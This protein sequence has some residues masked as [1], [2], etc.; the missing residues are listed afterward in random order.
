[1]KAM[2]LMRYSYFGISDWRSNASKDA[3]KLLSDARLEKRFSL[4]EKLPLA[5]LR[6]QTDPDFD[7]IVLGSEAMAD[8][9]KKRL[10]EAAKD[11][12]GIARATSCSSHSLRPRRTE[13]QA[14]KQASKHR[15]AACDRRGQAC[16]ASRS[17]AFRKAAKLRFAWAHGNLKY[18]SET[19]HPGP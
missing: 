8:K 5:A 14:S 13:Q 17:T 6:D 11:V 7:L 15:L 4:F 9:H 16:L 12:L 19:C 2:F 18:G 1:M 3:S 10:T